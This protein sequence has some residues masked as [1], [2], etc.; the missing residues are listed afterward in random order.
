MSDGEFESRLG[1]ARVG[2]T[3]DRK[4]QLQGQSPFLINASLNYTNDDMGLQT[5]LFFNMQGETLEVVGLG[6]VPDVFTLPFESLNFT[7]NKAFG[8]NKKSSIDVKVSNIL[9]AERESVF[10]SFRAEDRVFSLREPG[11]EFSIGYSYKF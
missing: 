10:Q 5:G 7:F 2:Q 4:R 3:I 1:S 9:G 11:T 6:G 8:E